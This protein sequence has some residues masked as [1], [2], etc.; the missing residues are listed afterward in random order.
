MELQHVLQSIGSIADLPGLIT[1]LGHRA[2]LEPIP[3][4]AWNKPGSRTFDLTLVGQT[5]DLPWFAIN[6]TQP[7]RDAV[8]L[9]RRIARRGKLA[10]VLALDSQG[11]QLGISVAFGRAPGLRVSLSTPDAESLA[12]LARL[13]GTPEGGALAFAARAADALSTEPVGRRFFREFKGTLDRMAAALPEPMPRADRHAVVLLQL[14]RVL[15]LYFIQ[16][17][18]WL[19]QRNQFLAEEVD[20]CLSR[21]CRI[22]RDFLRP[23]FFG[24]LNQPGPDRS[25]M[26]RQFGAIPFLNGGLFEPHVLERR[27]RAD[28]PNPLWCDAFD[29]LFERFHF[30]VSE[31]TKPGSVAPDMLGHVFE[32]VMD[33]DD[34]RASG[35]FY[36][37]AALVE[38]LVDAALTVVLAIRMGCSEQEAER[39]LIEQDPAAARVLDGITV[40]DPAVGSGA[41]LLGTLH[42]L[43]V[44][45]KPSGHAE[46]KRR[47]LQQSLFGVDRNAAAVRLAEL[48]LWL[49]VIADDPSNSAHAVRPLPNLD[50]LIRQ[51]DSL[52][53][54]G[55]LD[56]LSAASRQ[57]PALIT[58]ISQVRKQVIGATGPQKRSWVRQLRQ[59]EVRALGSSLCQAEVQ[60]SGVIAGYLQL[61]RAPDLFGRQRGLDRELC[62]GL[63]QE[64]AA[65]RRLRE[66]RR[67]LSRQEEVPWFHYRSA[68]A[69][70]FAQGGFDLVIGNPP[71]LRSEAIPHSTRRQIAARYR[72]WKCRGVGYGKSPDLAIAFLERAFDLARPRGIVAMLVP[73]KIATAGYGAEAR[74]ALASSTTLHVLAN[75]TGTREAAFDATVY[76]LALIAGNATPSLNQLVRT[77]LSYDTGDRLEQT[78]LRGG[79]P[80]I[81]KHSGVQAVLVDLEQQQTHLAENVTCHLGVKTGLNQVFLDPPADIEPML[82]RWAL[83]GRDVR[84]FR[85]CPKLRLLWTHDALGH[86]L[87]RLPPRAQA[88]LNQHADALRSRRDFQREPFWMVF[89]AVPAVARYRVVWSDLSRQLKA[90][91]LTT[92]N[93]SQ[94]IPLNTCYVAPVA[95]ALQA[96]ALAAW[97]NSTW[98]RAVAMLSAVPAAVGFFRFNAGVVTA[99]PL[100]PAAL[101]DRN[102]AQLALQGRAG[103]PVET[104]IDALVAHHLSL[105]ERAHRALRDALGPCPID[106]R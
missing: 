58:E 10:V 73:A 84:P 93:D 39:R 97:L 44:T 27:Y 61:A 86:P 31:G 32:G 40:L 21:G 37:P 30:T 70:V 95:S 47:V 13:A 60:R 102:L 104:E 67:R 51:G 19:G 78:E 52:F 20:R 12:S 46:R 17:K 103:H 82:L 69:D 11:R 7:G 5:T 63:S 41:F 57:D 26:A 56:L 96:H 79:A 18:G 43:S 75:V 62:T 34:R 100:P 14:T 29:R 15:F 98:I 77:N 91:A 23:L 99:L 38:R 72:W 71:W 87:S 6:S 53:D 105:P 76:P 64:R 80:W 9:A 89:R 28:I 106:H 42:R 81:L 101:A 1:R 48:R 50:C 90:A 24:T 35:T 25:R 65:L 94:C 2:K 8:L 33:P 22:H 3:H 16:S 83:R 4:S 36:T 74:H 88:H 68:F 59:L 49:S 66:A 85:C 54:P 55:G 45:G 92:R